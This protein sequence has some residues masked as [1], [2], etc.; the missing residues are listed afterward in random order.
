MR[1]SHDRRRVVLGQVQGRA[2]VDQQLGQHRPALGQR[3]RPEIHAVEV[4]EVECE[5]QGCR[6]AEF[7]DGSMEREEVRM[8][9]V[10]QHDSLAVDY[11][12]PGVDLSELPSDPGQ[13]G[14]QILAALRVDPDPAVQDVTLGAGAVEFQL[15]MPEIANRHPIGQLRLARRD[16]RDG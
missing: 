6:R 2:G 4:Q 3:F 14:R 15:I 11:G 12:P 7:R 13:A 8:A 5:Q 9:A 1:S 16:E 10:V